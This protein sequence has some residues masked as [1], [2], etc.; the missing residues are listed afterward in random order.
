MVMKNKILV[1]VIGQ[2]YV[3][4]PLALSCAK[5]GYQVSGIEVDK[6]RF[7]ALLDARVEKLGVGKAEVIAAQQSGLLSFK[8]DYATISNCDVIVICVPTPLSETG[9]PDLSILE[10]VCV[11]ISQHVK[12]GSLIINESTSHPGTL[13]NII[14][15]IFD[16]R[17]KKVK[18]AVAPE[19]IDPG[20]SVWRLENT[21]RVVGGID[22]ESTLAARGFYGKIC[23]SVSTVSSPEIAEFSKVYENT[24]RQVNI[25]LVNQLSRVARK[26]GLSFI[27]I[28]EAASTK[29]F[30]F[31][32]FFPGIGVGGHCIPIDPMYLFNLSQDLGVPASIIEIAQSINQQQPSY[33][34][35]EIEEMFSD[36]SLRVCLVGLGYKMGSGDLRESPAVNLLSVLRSRFTSVT[37]IDP[38]VE[39]WNGEVSESTK[40]TA[41]V[42]L[43]ANCAPALAAELQALHPNSKFIDLGGSHRNR[44]EGARQFF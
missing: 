9:M 4:L 16:S 17:K 38:N 14:Q 30:G 18:L 43:L 39:M 7:E 40:T 23:N 25:A 34:A 3:G 42:F 13:R 21:P 10:E 31:S 20:N 1:A 19:R 15:P 6:L 41:E 37:W 11:N 28:T 29:P 12:E 26:M 2:G 8:S 36:K 44:N 22:E 24:Y 5:A 27:E 32:T 35:K 33:V